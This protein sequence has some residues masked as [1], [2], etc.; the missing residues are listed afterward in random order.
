VSDF[1]GDGDPGLTVDKDSIPSTAPRWALEPGFARPF[2]LRGNVTVYLYLDS[3]TPSDT[4]SLTFTLY[5]GGTTTILSRTVSV[6]FNAFPD[7]QPFSW[8]LGSVDYWMAEGARLEF[9]ISMGILGDDVYVAYDGPTAPSRVVVTTETYVRIDAI[10]LEDANGP[11]ALFSTRDTVFI[12]ANVSDPLGAGEIS[13]VAIDV[14]DPDG[15]A[16]VTNAPLTLVTTD[17]GAV[18]AWKVFRYV[19]PNPSKEGMYT[20]ALTATEGNGVQSSRPGSFLV[21]IPILSLGATAIPSY[22]RPSD[23]VRFEIDFDNAGQGF[24]TAWFNVTLPSGFTYISDTS[25]ANGGSR[26]GPTNWT[27]SSI[28]PGNHRFDIDARV[29]RDVPAGVLTTR[30]TLAYADEKGFLWSVPPRDVAVTI[31]GPYLLAQLALDKA[32]TRRFE[33]L[34]ITVWFN[35][36]GDEASSTVWINDTLPSSLVYWT[37]DANGLAEFTSKDTS[38]PVLRYTFANVGVGAH[39]FTIWANGSMTLSPGDS[40]PIAVEV[41]Y[42]VSGGLGV[43]RSTASITAVGIG[44]VILGVVAGP[45]VGDPGDLLSLTLYYNNTGTEAASGAWVNFTLD[46]AMSY[47]SANPAPTSVSGSLVSWTFPTA[48]L[49]AHSIALTVRLAAG[50]GDGTVHR[51]LLTVA[52]ADVQGTVYGSPPDA[53]DVLVVA[54]VFSLGVSSSASQVEGGD[55]LTL[56]IAFPNMGGGTASDAWID[57]T[58]SD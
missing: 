47:V 23:V 21:R 50:V 53:H 25:S 42:R 41:A 11:A 29:N 2:R 51:A 52:Y 57:V 58:L 39:A 19:Y 35:N 20:F 15:V 6:T 45:T 56:T 28:G 34:G 16:V 32:G 36:T 33:T 18:P 40:I 54:P 5:D 30:V 10:T 24:A 22:A 27:F 48:S 14:T 1:D 3:K 12:E 46:P 8:D 55:L 44:P 43:A 26:T 7:W 13:G 17:P 31:G 4:A 49:G 9:R 38:G 37:D